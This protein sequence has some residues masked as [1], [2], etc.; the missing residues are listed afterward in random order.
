MKKC[1]YSSQ[2]E[3]ILAEAISP[4]ATE[5]RL[6]DAADLISLLRFEYYGSI[7]DL[8]TSAAELF[9]HPGTVNFGLGGNY[10]LE[11]GGKPEVVL[12]LEIKPR[13]VTVYAQLTLAEHHAG[14]D[15]SHIAFQEPSADPD[16]NTAFL[17]RSLRE[18]RYNTRP[19]QALAG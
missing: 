11:W 3:R 14:I 15:I 17:E 2:R 8:V 13:G 1:P 7:A 16:E 9:F 12:D 10:T 19:L 18:S 4:V 6:L 5:L